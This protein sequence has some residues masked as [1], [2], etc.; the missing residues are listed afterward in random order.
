M[1]LSGI[2]RWGGIQGTD[3]ASPFLHVCLHGLGDRDRFPSDCRMHDY[4]PTCYPKAPNSKRGWQEDDAAEF[5]SGLLANWPSWSELHQL[6]GIR[7]LGHSLGAERMHGYA[8]SCLNAGL[9]ITKLCHYAGWPPKQRADVPCVCLINRREVLLAQRWWSWT[10]V[11]R[12]D[13]NGVRKTAEMYG[14]RMIELGT[15]NKREPRHRW[16]AHENQR[17]LDLMAAA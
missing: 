13:V 11:L 5:T 12:K 3:H 17:I 2:I 4:G 14:T 6:E 8:V 9:P 7:L 10:W 16:L 15:G 1:S